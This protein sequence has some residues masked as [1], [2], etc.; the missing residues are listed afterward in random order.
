[1]LIEPQIAV[2]MVSIV[3]PWHHRQIVIWVVLAI[4]QRNVVGQ[5]E[6][7][8]TGMEKPL[9][10]DLDTTLELMVMDY[11]DA[12]REFDFCLCHFLATQLTTYSREGQN[13]RTLTNNV[14]GW[15]G[16]LTVAKCIAQCKLNNYALAGVE[17]AQECC[18]L[19]VHI[20]KN[21]H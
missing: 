12:L 20:F 21:H 19:K 2:T 5:T 11:W 4:P 14:N 10:Q 18:K 8:Y 9:L 16:K 6:S 1:L 7:Q 15:T 3:P 13:G 17:Y